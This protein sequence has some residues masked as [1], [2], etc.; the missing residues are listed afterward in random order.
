MAN[1]E[2]VS[3]ASH[4]KA[5]DYLS[6]SWGN[7]V[8]EESSISG[9]INETVFF[10]NEIGQRF[11]LQRNGLRRNPESL[12]AEYRFLEYLQENDFP[13]VKPI[14][15]GSLPFFTHDGEVYSVYPLIEAK[16]LDVNHPLQVR[17]AFEEMSRFLSLSSLYTQEEAIWRGRWWTVSNYPFENNFQFYLEQSPYAAPIMEIYQSSRDKLFDRIIVPA[18]RGLYGAGIIHSDFRPEHFLFE[19]STLKG[20]IDWSSSHYDIF[21]ME[22]ARPFLYLCQSADQ[23]EELLKVVNERL[24]LSQ[25]EIESAYYA[26]LLLELAEFMWVV[27]HK[28][29]LGKK[30]FKEELMISTERVINAHKISKEI[31]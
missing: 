11:V 2:N 24:R 10:R 17:R 18:R 4:I 12:V 8:V 26:P 13:A 15:I 3:G 23:R 16:T 1:K 9:S 25:E 21:V 20:I 19:S 31:S 30:V 7:L 5:L 6:Q 14:T 28:D 27:K 29:S 22:F